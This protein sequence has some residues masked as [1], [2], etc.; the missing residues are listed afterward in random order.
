M[1]NHGGRQGQPRRGVH[2]EKLPGG[3]A[4]AAGSG[5]KEGREEVDER[6]RDEL[7]DEAGGGRAVGVGV[8]GVAAPAGAG[9][10][11]GG[12]GRRVATHE[13]V[14][15]EKVSLGESERADG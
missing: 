14:E 6:E 1:G 7:G 15:A 9:A 5:A 2:G 11:G 13:G 12:G 8:G 10:A 4:A 3:R